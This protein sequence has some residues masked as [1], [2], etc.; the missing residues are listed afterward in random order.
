[1]HYRI[2]EEPTAYKWFLSITAIVVLIVAAVMGA[3]IM[4]GVK[5]FL[6]GVAP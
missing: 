5:A 3:K 6:A 4:I 1:M 2:D